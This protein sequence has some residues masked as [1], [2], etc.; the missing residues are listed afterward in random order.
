MLFELL[1]QGVLHARVELESF[2]E[3]SC[4]FLQI[5]PLV[6]PNPPRLHWGYVDVYV[7]DQFPLLPIV[8][9]HGR[10]FHLS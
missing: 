5:S 8:G 3:V 1:N 4:Q 9:Q 10:G 6:D 2:A 7:H